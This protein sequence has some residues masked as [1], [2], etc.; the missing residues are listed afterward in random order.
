M[1]GPEL[2]GSYVGESE[3]NVRAAFAS[4]REA[5][6]SAAKRSR[7]GTAILFFDEI[8]SIAPKRGGVGDGG[9]VM[10]RVVAT[11]LGEL[12]KDETDSQ[13]KRL[14]E[15]INVF[16]IGATNRPDLLDPALLR[17]GRF[18]VMVY[19][20][21]AKSRSDRICILAA[22]TR[23]FTFKDDI[24]SFSMASQVIDSIP[25]SLSGADFSAVASGALTRS[26]KRQC[27]K[28]DAE[29]SRQDENNLNLEGFIAELAEEHLVPTVTADDIIL[30]AM[31]VNP[32][33]DQR[34]L[35][36]YETL[37]EQFCGK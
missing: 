26:L 19:L 28:A 32:S 2:L 17:P 13:Q 33:V 25:D 8:D 24:D 5:A 11:L 22:Q 7:G 36:T 12:D 6:A 30:A 29:V 21:L 35:K 15:V 3:A 14:D 34:D 18:D 10:E 27:E 16:V 20:G 9:G 4:A 31:L 1:K 23:N 37:K